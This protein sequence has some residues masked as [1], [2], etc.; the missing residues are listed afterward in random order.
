MDA[1]ILDHILLELYRLV[2][3]FGQ[4]PLVVILTWRGLPLPTYVLAAEKYGR[5]L[6]DKVYLL[7]LLSIAVC[8]GTWATP[9]TPG[10]PP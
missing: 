8:A 5:C 3:A 9:R 10:R 7:T 6:R 4:Q 2:C 1:A